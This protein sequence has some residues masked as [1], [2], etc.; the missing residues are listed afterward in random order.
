VIRRRAGL[1]WLVAV[2]GTWMLTTAVLAVLISQRHSHAAAGALLSQASGS[3]LLACV[4]IAGPATAVTLRVRHNLGFGQAVLAG[5]A[6]AAGIMAFICSFMAAS[7]TALRGTWSAVT[8]VIMI[9]VVE[10]GLALAVRG[11]TR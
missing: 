10:L 4:V 3:A 7:G 1:V 6:V 2:A 8:P 9:T 5:L 11:R